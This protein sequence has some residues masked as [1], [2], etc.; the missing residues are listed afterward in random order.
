MENF[1]QELR[2][3]ARF[4][5]SI[6]VIAS[7]LT[8]GAVFAQETA[9]TAVLR[10]KTDQA[11][12]IARLETTIPPLMKEGDVPGLAVA[13]VR[14]GELAWQR[15][16]G[17][18][19][20]KT[21]EAVKDDTVFEAASLSKPVF[22]YAVL[23]L[24]DAG[25]FDLDK[26]L[27]QYLPGNYDVGDDHRLG[28]ITARRVLSHTTGFPNWRN[29]ALRI[30]FT[31]GERFSYSGEGFVY[32]SKV[33]EHITGEKFNDFMKR[34]VFE[35]LAMTS[36]SYVWQESYERLKVFRHNTRGQA[37]GQNK[38]PPGAANAAASLHTTARDYGRFVAAMLKGIGLKPETRRLM[39]T[40]QSQV[41]EGGATTINRPDAKP[42]P[43]VF[44]G[45]G[46]GLQTTREGPSFF[47]WGDNG[48][49]KAYVVAFDKEKMGV[50]VF[51]NSV[52]GLSIVREI[53]T[54]AVGGE[55]P[56][57][58]WLRYE[59]YRSP[60]RSLFKNAMAK[61][62]EVALNEYRE[63]RGGRPADEAISEDQMNRIGYDLLQMGR[64][65]DAVELFKQN[66][67]DHPQSF[68]VYDSLGEA[69]AANGDNE[70]AIKNYER[71]IELNRENRDGIEALRKLLIA[72]RPARGA[73]L[74]KQALSAYQQKDYGKSAQ[75][76][77]AAIGA[78]D[79]NSDNY[80]NGACSF[81]L[82]GRKN[83]AFDLLEQLLERGI[84][85]AESMKKGADFNNLRADARW[86]PLIDRFEAKQKSQAVFWNSPSLKTAFRA[87]LGEDEKVAG[88]SKFWSEVRFNFANFDLVPA[89]DWDKL[90]LEYLP[91]VRQTKSTLEYYQALR[92]LCAKLKDGHT[93]VYFPTE[94]TDETLARPLIATRLIE[95]KVIIRAVFD[96]ELKKEGI[97]PGLE[98]VE[99]DGTPVK[100]Y[101]EQRVA[102]YQSASTRQDL[103]V[104]T[105][106][107][108]LLSG[109]AKESVEL[110]LSDGR[111]SVFKKSLP[112]FT[113]AERVNLLPKNTPMEFKVLP[114]N[115]G[116]VALN[117]FDDQQVVQQFEAAFA[118]IAKTDALVIDIRNNGGGDSGLGYRILS[119]LTDKPFKTSRWRTRSYR[120][121]FRAWGAPE[122]WH[123][124]GRGERSPHG[125]K[126]YANPVVLLTSPRTYS[127]AEDFAVA[128]DVMR[129]GKIIGEAT[130]GSTGQPLFFDLPG[131]GRARVCTKRDSYPDGREFVG[132]GVQPQVA[133]AQT[134]ADFRANRD[135]VLEAALAEL[136]KALKSD[137]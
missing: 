80:Y 93:G 117:G 95:D 15:G 135:S 6:A 60:A 23:K 48:D 109:P 136:K 73:G 129:R 5:L 19:S 34:T 32:L 92:E 137:R 42:F 44:W 18:M 64:I 125:V 107:Y 11:Q 22:A 126:L 104:R 98:I 17:V 14:N 87:N 75:L 26:P 38:L 51:A 110:T 128:F 53:L 27:N 122:D 40:P 127:A 77:L 56:A 47:H 12:I 124:G 112:R 46:W 8:I 72:A 113:A 131:G 41:R 103:N 57:L 35:P 97:E 52:Y 115:I 45:L 88:L 79:Q 74:A 16:F 67:A 13:L 10:T 54:E 7:T 119:S 59:S 118:E 65:R 66:V 94:L 37:V 114:G 62:A 130:G 28:Q 90:Y 39:L 63:W 24:V 89:L 31:P 100:Q 86:A 76:Y 134:V 81:S 91:K 25:R 120:P 69:Y 111:G 84:I 33:I 106:E 2:Y 68:N 108:S 4:I 123:D 21:G 49:C 70:L 101:A 85:V 50:V 96:E 55:Q 132:Y 133:V 102:P 9:K 36:S 1:G 116:Y 20:V 99:I 61:G 43:E 58:A 3:G 71:S 78:G 29:G 105:F 83:E 121:S 30:F 82:A